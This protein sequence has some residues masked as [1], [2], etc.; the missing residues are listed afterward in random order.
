MFC[1][2]CGKE[3]DNNADV[4]IYCGVKVDKSEADARK[5][6]AFGI[7]GFVVALLSLWL[8]VYFCIASIIGL[9]LSGV[10]MGMSKK[11]NSCNGLAIAGLV[12]AIISLVVWAIIWIIVGSAILAVMA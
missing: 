2:N 10:G 3:I 12:I 11:C 5:I 4:C 7:A 9:V 6:N 8:G 1:K